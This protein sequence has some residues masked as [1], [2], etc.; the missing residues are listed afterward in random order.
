MKRYL[1]A[2]VILCA[3]HRAA[4]PT[5]TM[6]WRVGAWSEHLRGDG[7]VVRTA[8]AT[9]ITFRASHEYVE[10]HTTVIE[11]QDK[12]VYIIGRSKHVVAIGRW[13]QDGSEIKV[14]RQKV[15]PAN[16][17]DVLCNQAEL[18]FR[19]SGESVVGDTGELTS[20]TY[21]PVT[22]LVTPDFENYVNDTKRVGVACPEKK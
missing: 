10:H 15:A 18:R 9:I 7:S 11:Q 14:T 8:P 3:C 21:A 16:A 22:R 12:S 17:R 20:G 19:I 13:E 5:N 6:L 4:M 2:V 1:A